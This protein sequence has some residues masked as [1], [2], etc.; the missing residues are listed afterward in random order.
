MA[1]HLPSQLSHTGRMTQHTSFCCW[2]SLAGQLTFV[3]VLHVSESLP[4]Q[5]QS[6]SSARCFWLAVARPVNMQTFPAVLGWSVEDD[7][8]PKLRFFESLRPAGKRLLDTMYDQ[9]MGYLQARGQGRAA[10]SCPCVPALLQGC[11]SLVCC[12][13]GCT[14]ACSAMVRLSKSPTGQVMHGLLN[15]CQQLIIS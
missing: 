3:F 1:A 5:Q 12:D 9:D 11:T 2:P 7:L 13:A 4:Q 10:A 8:L 15:S 6:L 14:C